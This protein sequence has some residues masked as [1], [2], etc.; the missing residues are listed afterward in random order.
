ML[1]HGSEEA[2]KRALTTVGAVLVLCAAFVAGL[3]MVFKP[4]GGRSADE[5][6]VSIQTPYIGPGV[7]KG[8]ELVL[9]G[10]KVGAVTAVANLPGGGVRLNADLQKA[11]I[12]GLTDALDIDFRPINYFG[13][14]GI[15][16]IAR[17]GGSPLHDGIHLQIAPKGNFALQALL[18]RLGRLATG[19]LTTRLIQVVDKATRYTDALNPLIETMIISANALADT[20]TVSTEQ[21]LRNTTGVSVAF[22]SFTDALLD[23]SYAVTH[24]TNKLGRGVWNATEHEYSDIIEP[25]MSFVADNLFG[26][27]GKLE[28]SHT[29]DLLPVVDSITALTDV[30]PSLIRPVGISEMLVELRSRIEKMYEGGPEQRA[31]QVRIVL[32]SLPGIAAPLAAVGA[33]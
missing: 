25:F 13:V 8:T 12:A 14:T 9:H 28:Y 30:V 15:N 11:P 5:I 6:S 32:D 33:P 4:F 2:E 3:V 1:L 24:G 26:A 23:A 21:L 16:L 10:V 17:E 20:Q 7:A 22:P 27:I 18:S 29:E 31:M 19:T